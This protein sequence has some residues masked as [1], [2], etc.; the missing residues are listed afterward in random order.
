MNLF[1]AIGIAAGVFCIVRG[2]VDL[3]QRRYVWGI[4]GIAVGLAILSAPFQTQTV[5][6]DLPAPSQR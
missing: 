6:Y 5:K 4:L 2:A 3:W 1:V